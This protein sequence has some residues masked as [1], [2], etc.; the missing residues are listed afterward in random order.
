MSV[1]IGG[2]GSSG[3]TMLISKLSTHPELF[4]GGEINF[5]NKEQLFEDWN[6]NKM[7]I[8]P[9]F[10][11]F[12]TKG[13]HIYR[14]NSLHRSEYGWTKEEIK[15][16]L[17]TS[18]SINNFSEQY[19]N[20]PL[21]KKGAKFWIE[22]TPSNCYSFSLFLKTF[23]KSKVVHIA[24]NPLDTI[25]SIYKKDQRV[26]HAVGNWLYNNATALNVSDSENYYL[27]KYEDLIYDTNNSFSKLCLFLGIDSK[28]IKLDLGIDNKLIPTWNNSPTAKISDSSMGKF[29]FLSQEVKDE[30]YTALA[31][32]E[33]S[34]S[35]KNKKNI[36]YID[37]NTI[38][39]K[40]NYSSVIHP[41]ESMLKK[42]KLDLKKDKLNR[43]IKMYATGGDFYPIQLKDIL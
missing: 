9:L 32:F 27:I 42:I 41:K 20:R 16:L 13:W 11:F 35:H 36:K 8:L 37:F 28:D 24:R 18:H 23:P 29:N 40:L 31:Y 22:K 17:K 26:F 21:L 2:S 19:F 7:K 12:S 43:T 3:S 34:D 1:I 38:C 33:V 30:I 5:F 6:K 15:K 10:P 4:C 14:R 25:A 39:E